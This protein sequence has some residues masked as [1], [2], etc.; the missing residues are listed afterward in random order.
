M[1]LFLERSI[2]KMPLFVKFVSEPDAH[3][4]FKFQ[5]STNDESMKTY[6][7]IPREDGQ[8]AAIAEGASRAASMHRT[9]KAAISAARTL[10]QKN[11]GELR[12]HGA[13][14]RIRDSG[15]E[16]APS[17]PKTNAGTPLATR[18]PEKMQRYA[19]K[20]GERL[21]QARMMRGH[22]LRSLADKLEGIASHTTLQKFEK[23]I[24]TPDTKILG[25]IARILDV[26]IGYF[27]KTEGLRLETIEYRKSSKV[28]KKVAHQL[29]EQA[30]EF[31]ERYLE[32]EEILGIKGANFEPE[33]FSTMPKSALPAAIEDLTLRLRNEWGLG[34]NPI[35]NV[36]TTLEQHGVKVRLLPDA[37]GFDGL[38]GFA[39]LAGR[40]IPTIAVSNECM[41]SDLP[42][43]RFTLLHEL[44]HLAMSLP[45]TLEHKEKEACCHRFAGAF[46]FP[47]ASVYAILGK[48]R[49]KILLAELKQIKSEWGVS[50]AALMRRS[51]DLAIISPGTYKGFCIWKNG[52][53]GF[54][55]NEPQTW[56]GSERSDRFEQ[57]VFRAFAESQ[58]SVSKAADLLGLSLGEFAEKSEGL[59]E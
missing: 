46:L 3:E 48:E 33:N 16:S 27:F 19:T 55:K 28:G 15:G 20:I 35:A 34:S 44:G 11:K 50:I 47:K 23:G 2:Y 43:L 6:H 13:D 40:K 56:I 37:E 31:F 53:H 21:Q 29:A 26:R 38:A 51:L 39:V 4:S 32:I 59:I 45:E 12:I 57:L 42:R 5:K 36:H 17:R 30:A 54:G 14:G 58:I 8:W 52:P 10:I 1:L 18:N 9:Q 41:S 49:K 25:K 24:N 22:S 7:V